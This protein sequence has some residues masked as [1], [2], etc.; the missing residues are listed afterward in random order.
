MSAIRFSCHTNTSATWERVEVRAPHCT[1]VV[2]IR[3]RYIFTFKPLCIGIP[4]KNFLSSRDVF[5]GLESVYV[6]C[7]SVVHV[8]IHAHCILLEHWDSHIQNQYAPENKCCSTAELK[9]PHWH[10]RG[11]LK[12]SRNRGLKPC[13]SRCGQRHNGERLEFSG[14]F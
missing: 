5:C 12:P 13:A 6:F 7:V 9:L 10:C 8:Y 14:S 2:N 1:R 3:V 11:G 4:D